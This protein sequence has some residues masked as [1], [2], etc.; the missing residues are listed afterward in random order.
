MIFGFNTD[1]K[2]DGTVYHVQSEARQQEKLLQTQVFLRGRCIGKRAS[3]YGDGISAQPAEVPKPA[4][5]TLSDPE[6]EQLLREQHK[7]VSDALK[8]GRLESVLDKHETPEGLAAVRQLDLQWVNSGDVFT[9]SAL[10]M[11]V[12]VTE[13]GT[14]L[15]GA[16]LISRLDRPE[17][18]PAFG[19]ATA[20]ADGKADIRLSLTEAALAEAS[21][22]VQASHQGRIVTK[23][24][25]FRKSTE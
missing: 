16:K 17:Q 14:A 15:P 7:L 23:K 18:K 4:E 5:G 9:D 13:A 24:F 3:R 8:E 12:L 21:I 1:I 25:T 10:L 19:E 20:A 22:L 11:Q 2:H 6:V